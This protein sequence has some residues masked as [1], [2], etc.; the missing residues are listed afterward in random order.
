MVSAL[1]AGATDALDAMPRVV[2]I[3]PARQLALF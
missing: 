3:K 1:D 2:V